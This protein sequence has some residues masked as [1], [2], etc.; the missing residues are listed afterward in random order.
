MKRLVIGIA[1]VGL[2]AGACNSSTTK[3]QGSSD[4]IRLG[5]FPNLT[6]SPGL[7]GITQGILDKDLA[8]TKVKIVP[9]TSGSE[10]SSALASGSIDA[11]YVGPN[12]AVSIF[13]KTNGQFVI[14][15]GATLGGA[16]LVVRNGSGITTPA[17]LKGKKVADPGIGNTQDVALRTWLH[18]H[19]LK[20]TDEGGD[21]TVVPLSSNS[22]SIT[23]MQN[24]QI[25]AAWQPEP[26]VSLL[27]S[28]NLGHVFVNEA[29]LW[30][31][32]KFST[33]NLLVSKTY[34]SAHPSVVKKLVQANVDSIQY[35]QQNSQA[36]AAA[37]NT[38]VA[39]LGGKSLDSSALSRAWAE[40]TFTWDPD[41]SSI[42]TDA[43]RAYALKDI[44]TNPTNISSLYDLSD[45][46]AILQSK[47][48]PTVQVSG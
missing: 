3:A 20:A 5:V 42:T 44:S 25:D 36:A 16:A 23:L 41:T 9:F 31:G 43:Q 46:N 18:E 34:M 48:L 33:T 7:I 45:L 47:G 24:K 14:V 28:E 39:T 40:M 4:E 35:I 27:V 30:P 38:E 26:Y 21:V 22:D 8:P 6:H 10:A 15:S 32:G 2:I 29:S 11:S 1:I 13:E 37:A 17:D 12:P 19:G